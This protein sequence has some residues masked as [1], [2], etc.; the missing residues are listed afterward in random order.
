MSAPPEPIQP[1]S[2][3]KAELPR[4]FVLLGIG[5]MVVGLIGTIALVAS[6]SSCNSATNL[7]SLSTSMAASG[8]CAHADGLLTVGFLTLV[9]GAALLIT[10]GMVLPTLRTRDAR[11]TAQAQAN[12]AAEAKL[13]TEGDALSD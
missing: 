1:I 7:Q 12:E 6:D 8:F 13:L 5:L 2:P 11:F 10:G 9:V 3:L 4:L